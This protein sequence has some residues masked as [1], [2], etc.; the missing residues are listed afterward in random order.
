MI[1]SH[2]LTQLSLGLTLPLVVGLS[3]CRPPETTD[4]S[5]P[6]SPPRAEEPTDSPMGPDDPMAPKASPGMDSPG[7]NG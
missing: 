1:Y 7:M 3:S 6:E 5:T 4:S 2:R